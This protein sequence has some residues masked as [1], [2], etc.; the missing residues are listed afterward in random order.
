MVLQARTTG[1]PTAFHSALAA[2]APSRFIRCQSTVEDQKLA[3]EAELKLLPANPHP[4]SD[5]RYHRQPS[6]FS[7]PSHKLL[8]LST[9][10]TVNCPYLKKKLP[11][12]HSLKEPAFSEGGYPLKLRISTT[13][14][15][16]LA[17]LV[18]RPSTRCTNSLS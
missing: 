14:E 12:F 8:L 2:Q 17:S 7:A 3:L 4:V 1:Y 5:P 16:V 10:G 15:I 13:D 11:I 6:L 18:Y 9:N